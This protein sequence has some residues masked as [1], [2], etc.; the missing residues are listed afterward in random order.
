MH[1]NYIAWYHTEPKWLPWLTQCICGCVHTD[2]G[3][4]NSLPQWAIIVIAIVAVVIFAVIVVGV[5]G[6]ALS[7]LTRSR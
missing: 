7:I 4:D 5:L 6:L 2:P 3:T 1:H